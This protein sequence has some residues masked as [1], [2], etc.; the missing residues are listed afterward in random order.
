MIKKVFLLLVALTIVGQIIY[1]AW[2]P[3]SF[4]VLILKTIATVY[5]VKILGDMI[6]KFVL[7]LP[8]YDWVYIRDYIKNNLGSTSALY[9]AFAVLWYVPIG[10]DF[11]WEKSPSLFM[12]VWAG[13][14]IPAVFYCIVNL[15]DIIGEEPN[16]DRLRRKL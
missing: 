14:L 12:S 5:I 4:E 7:K 1:I 16:K 10:L 15:Y 8:N 2:T 9:F 6:S 13:G 11:Y 3:D